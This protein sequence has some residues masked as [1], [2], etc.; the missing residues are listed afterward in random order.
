MGGAHDV[1]A[2]RRGVLKGVPGIVAN[3]LRRAQDDVLVPDAA[4]QAQPVADPLL[5]PLDVHAAAGLDAL[6]GIIDL[7]QFVDH[8]PHLPAAVL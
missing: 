2:A 4:P 1:A 3:V 5:E 7:G 8:R 6:V